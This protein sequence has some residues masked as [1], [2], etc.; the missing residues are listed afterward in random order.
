MMCLT[1]VLGVERAGYAH[2]EPLPPDKDVETNGRTFGA[3]N[4]PVVPAA[5]RWLLESCSGV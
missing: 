5:V 4:D 3:G 2:D 1:I